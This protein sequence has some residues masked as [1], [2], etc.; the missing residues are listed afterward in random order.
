MAM[1]GFSSRIQDY[2]YLAKWENNLAVNKDH[3]YRHIK[4]HDAAS[5]WARWQNTNFAEAGPQYFRHWLSCQ[6]VYGAA[7]DDC[8]K[9]R[10]WATKV[11]SPPVLAEWDDWWKDEHYDIKIGQHWNRICDEEFEEAANMLKDLKEKREGLAAKFRD[12]LKAKA[13]EDPMEKILKEVSQMEEVSKT[14]VADL[15]EAGTLSQTEVELAAEL[16]IKELQA[17]QSDVVWSDIKGSLLKGLIAT[18]QSLKSS[19]KVVE[20]IKAEEEADIAQSKMNVTKFEV[21]H[22]RVN[23]EKPGLYEYET[24]F[25]KF[26]PRTTQFGFVEEEEE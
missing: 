20:E 16:K 24:W 8:R 6:Q 7:N 3:L 21:P 5:I 25:G 26:I 2:K 1:E 13:D 10:W 19:A 14:P 9:L 18:C 12:L 11:A 17:L 23:Y 22:M 15:V 4:F